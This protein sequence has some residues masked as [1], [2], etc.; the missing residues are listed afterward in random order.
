MRLFSHE[1]EKR[2]YSKEW[3]TKVK[4]YL[5]LEPYLRCWM[6]PDEVFGGKKILDIGAGECEYSRL[7]VD[8]YN[9]KEII[10]CDL[11]EERMQLAKTE[12]KNPKLKF[13]TGDV[14]DLPFETNSFDVVFGSLVLHQLPNLGDVVGE[15]NRVLKPKGVYVGFEPNPF[16][17]II[18]FR[19]FFK[20]HS[21]NQYLFWPWLAKDAF[22]T[23]DFDVK[24][25]YFYAKVPWV[26]NQFLG[27]CIGIIANL[28]D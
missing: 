1:L 16:N 28:N 6:N 2:Y 9:P 24:I 13:V 22:N 12:N 25:C 21:S 15:V 8:K 20:K 23:A 17:M 26:K 3:P 4:P 14:F 7:I 27:T 18:L 19:H 10:A 5:H 11:F